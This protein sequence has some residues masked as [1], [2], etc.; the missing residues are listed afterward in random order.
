VFGS[1]FTPE[2]PATFAEL[3]KRSE[4]FAKLNPR[5]EEEKKTMQSFFFFNMEDL[6]Q[7]EMKRQVDY[8]VS[9]AISEKNKEIK[10]LKKTIEDEYNQRMETEAIAADLEVKVQK[11]RKTIYNMGIERVKMM[12]EA[13]QREPT[14]GDS[15]GITSSGYL[16]QRSCFL[17]SNGRCKDH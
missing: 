11:C 8:A 1:G 6:F 17:D 13:R 10:Q 7:A 12:M 5:M 3:S 9:V 16:C 4:S 15:G 14:C 2:P